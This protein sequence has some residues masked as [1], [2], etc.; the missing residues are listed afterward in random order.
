MV[1]RQKTWLSSAVSFIVCS[2][3]SYSIVVKHLNT[4]SQILEKQHVVFSSSSLLEERE[5]PTLW[6]WLMIKYLGVDC[7]AFNS[8]PYPNKFI[9]LGCAHSSTFHNLS[10][11]SS[12]FSW[13]R[14]WYSKKVQ[15]NQEIILQRG[16]ITLKHIYI[17]CKCLKKT[18]FKYCIRRIWN[19]FNLIQS[20]YHLTKTH[21][22]NTMRDPVNNM[23]NI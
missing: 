23:A 11:S 15:T 3:T 7:M 12:S 13:S 4:F 18:L 8:P 6:F 14:A 16:L 1:K 9:N 2:S 21:F 5:M 17:L 20:F 22:Q 19:D 10:S